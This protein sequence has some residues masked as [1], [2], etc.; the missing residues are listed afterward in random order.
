[1]LT[2]CV[3]CFGTRQEGPTLDRHNQRDVAESLLHRQVAARIEAEGSGPLL[4]V[5]ENG[6]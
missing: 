4:V 2:A 6:K 5:K 1:M 3:A